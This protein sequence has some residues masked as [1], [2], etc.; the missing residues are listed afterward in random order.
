LI[1]PEIGFTDF[2]LNQLSTLAVTT[3]LVGAGWF[4]GTIEDQLVSN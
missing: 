2:R 3:G 4:F 1:E